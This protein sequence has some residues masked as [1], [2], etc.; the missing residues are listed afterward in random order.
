MPGLS[1]VSDTIEHPIHGKRLPKPA[2]RPRAVSPLRVASVVFR[3][4]ALPVRM[5][6]AMEETEPVPSEDGWILT[7]HV[8]KVDSS[9]GGTRNVLQSESYN[10]RRGADSESAEEKK[11]RLEVKR[12]SRRRALDKF[13]EVRREASK[14]K[15]R[16]PAKQAAAAAAALPAATGFATPPLQVPMALADA[17]EP[18]DIATQRDW[19]LLRAFKLLPSPDAVLESL[20]S[21]GLDDEDEPWTVLRVQERHDF[22][23]G[24]CVMRLG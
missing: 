15:R 20:R 12:K 4:S 11:K 1:P 2:T 13:D 3:P 10:Y 22:C 8:N 19:A 17:E 23:A 14:A 24:A 5:T 21:Q 16:K 6:V 18:P 9:P 7:V